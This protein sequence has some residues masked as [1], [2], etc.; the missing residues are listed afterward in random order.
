MSVNKWAL[1]LF[2]SIQRGGQ[3][4][5]SVTPNV[6]ASWKRSKRAIGGDWIGTFELIDRRVDRTIGISQDAML[7]LFLDGLG[8]EVRE[9]VGGGMQTWQGYIGEMELALDG[10][11]YVRSLV[12]PVVANACKN[13]YTRLYDEQLTNGGAE[14]GA[15]TALDG[16]TSTQV[17]DWVNSGQYSCK[18]VTGDTAAHVFRMGTVTIVA[19]V[20]YICT[21]ILHILSGTWKVRLLRADT[22]AALDEGTRHDAGDVNISINV[23]ASNTYSGDVYVEVKSINTVGTCYGDS[24][25][26]Q[27]APVPD[28]QTGWVIDPDS[29]AQYGRCEQATRLVG[30]TPEAA[31]SR[32]K[33]DLIKQAWPRTRRPG[34]LTSFDYDVTT[35]ENRLTITALGYVHTLA[36]QYCQAIGRSAYTSVQVAAIISEA[37]FVTAGTI[38]LNENPYT[39]DPGAP[40]RHWQALQDM[41]VASDDTGTGTRWL[42]GVFSH[43]LF[44]YRPA[45]NTI[46]YHYRKGRY[47]NVKG[48]LQEPWLAQPGYLLYLD[49]APVTPAPIAGRFEA[50]PRIEY[51]AEVEMNP[52]TPEQPWGVL[53]M[54]PEV[55]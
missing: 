36:N 40:I 37:E 43:R 23:P 4:K 38:K 49:D 45:P 44:D 46:N 13:I 53:I 39:I 21:G 20:A 17:T 1:D 14:S 12:S 26:F 30:M 41:I 11:A 9:T 55:M 52:P 10:V 29:I 50:D 6:K 24:F 18:M 8:Y 34:D 54:R 7:E 2:S 27:R 15:W 5:R 16:A 33:A 32:A 22:G 47:Y 31:I 42:G 51:V 19:N 28:T 3:H 35:A 48:G 25:S